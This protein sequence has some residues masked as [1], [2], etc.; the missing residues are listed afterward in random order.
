MDG[1]RKGNRDGFQNMTDRLQK[2]G[3]TPV[4][5]QSDKLFI[6]FYY[7][8]RPYERNKLKSKQGPE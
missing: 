7:W 3:I 1:L 4:T 2:Y 6:Y 8:A 5:E